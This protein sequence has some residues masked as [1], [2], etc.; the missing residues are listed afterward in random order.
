MEQGLKTDPSQYSPLVLAYLG[1]AVYELMIREHIVRQANRQVSKLHHEATQYV[2]AAAQAQLAER[3]LERLTEE[4]LAVYRRGRNAT[5]HTVPKNQETGDYRKATGL[6]AL[7]GWLYLKGDTDRIFE[8]AG[9]E[10]TEA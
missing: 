7:I 6:E 1:D 5:S 4:E 2:N 8:L 10:E 9:P 3:I